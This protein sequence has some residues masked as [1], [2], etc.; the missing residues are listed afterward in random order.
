MPEREKLRVLAD[1]NGKRYAKQFT[2][3]QLE[4]H[5]AKNPGHTLIR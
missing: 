2:P 3:A 1:E 4:E 5:L